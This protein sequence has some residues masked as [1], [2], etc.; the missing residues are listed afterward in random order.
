LRRYRGMLRRGC[1]QFGVGVGRCDG[2]PRTRM[3]L[4]G[5][6]V[7]VPVMLATAQLHI[8]VATEPK[9]PANPQN[10]DW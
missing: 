4:G 10:G 3:R 6:G 2:R 9:L 1:S 7:A 5:V 8:G